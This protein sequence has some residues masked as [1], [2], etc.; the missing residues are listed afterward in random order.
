MSS[1]IEMAKNI[2]NLFK[3]IKVT[4][5]RQSNPWE[6]GQYWRY[7]HTSSQATLWSHSN[8]NNI[9]L[10]QKQEYS[11]RKQSKE[12]RLNTHTHTHLQTSD[13]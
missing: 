7:Y 5:G 4:S 11:Q 12:P 9:V 6:K 1:F 2:N 3:S 10:A 8:K 13:F